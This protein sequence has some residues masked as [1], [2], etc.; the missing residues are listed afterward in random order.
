MD[1]GGSV[2]GGGSNNANNRRPPYSN[3]RYNPPPN[4]RNGRR[5]SSEFTRKDSPPSHFVTNEDSYGEFLAWKES[6]S[7]ASRRERSEEDASTGAHDSR[8]RRVSMFNM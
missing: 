8:H 4:N 5:A 2:C 3:D 6:N 1:R 7:R